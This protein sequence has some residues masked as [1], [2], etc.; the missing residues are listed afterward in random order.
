MIRESLKNEI[1]YLYLD[2]IVAK[3]IVFIK[4]QTR[5]VKMINGYIDNNKVFFDYSDHSPVVAEIELLS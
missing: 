2:Y 4:V 3:N 5:L 1:W